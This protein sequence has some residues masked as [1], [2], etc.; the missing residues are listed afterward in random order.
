M[1]QLEEDYKR[2]ENK[3]FPT[4]MRKIPEPVDPT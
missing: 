2:E 4:Q 1:N 3:P